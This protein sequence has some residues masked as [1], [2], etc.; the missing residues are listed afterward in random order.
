MADRSSFASHGSRGCESD[1]AGDLWCG[2]GGNVRGLRHTSARAGISGTARLACSG[3]Y[4]TRLESQASDSHNSDQ[5]HVSTI[6]AGDSRTAGTRSHQSSAGTGTAFPGRCG[7]RAG[8]RVDGI[9]ID[10][11]QDR[12]AGNH[13]TSTSKRARLQLHVSGLLDSGDWC[14]TISPHRLWFPQ[15]FNAGSGD[16]EL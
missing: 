11:A 13:P 1:V 7:S 5:C 14:G 3:L 8:H 12:W 4:G 10:Y 16:V 15:T 6:F 2:A 9:W